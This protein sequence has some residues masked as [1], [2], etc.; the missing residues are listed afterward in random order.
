MITQSDLINTNSIK[1]SYFGGITI[2]LLFVLIFAA[3]VE[4]I[5]LFS[6]KDDWNSIRCEPSIMPFAGL[7]GYD[8]NENFQYC[9]RQ[10][11][12]SQATESIAPVYSVLGGFV[13]VL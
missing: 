11:F 9:M 10:S 8:V 4:A 5:I 7:Y 2:L 1:S 6:R 13:G 12:N 3:I